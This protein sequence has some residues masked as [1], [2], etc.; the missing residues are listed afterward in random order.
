MKKV[1]GTLAAALLAAAGAP[2]QTPAAQP[3]KIAVINMQAAIVGTRDGQKA[4]ADLDGKYGPKRK[5]VDAQQ[6]E[7]NQ[8]REQLQ[9]GQ[10][11]L[12]DA[13]KNEIY[14]NIDQKTKT[15]NRDME[16]DQADLEQ[17]QSRYIQEI[18]QKLGV[19]INKYARDNGYSLVID[20]SGQQ[21]PVIF[22]SNTI[23]ITKQIIDLYDT[24]AAAMAPSTPPAA[25]QIQPATAK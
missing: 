6:A 12:S 15:L 8:L 19:V 10:N 14:K 16:D 18:G 24:N 7:I 9:K 22:A 17:D 5:A 23:D 3:A 25:P 20:V 1:I 21:S 4:A 13:A 2:A 11:T